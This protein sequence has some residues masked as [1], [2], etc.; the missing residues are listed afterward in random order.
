LNELRMD[1]REE[2][3]GQKE[4]LQLTRYE[5]GHLHL[6]YQALPLRA[7]ATGQTPAPPPDSG[8]PPWKAARAHSGLARPP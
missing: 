4:S 1:R 8:S 2:Y 7:P 5:F 6:E 3:G